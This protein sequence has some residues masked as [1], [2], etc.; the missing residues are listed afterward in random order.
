MSRCSEEHGKEPLWVSDT[1][2]SAASVSHLCCVFW[3]TLVLSLLMS[4]FK[5]AQSHCWK[6]ICDFLTMPHCCEELKNKVI[7]LAMENCIWIWF[8]IDNKNVI[9]LKLNFTIVWYLLDNNILQ[10]MWCFYLLSLWPYFLSPKHTLWIKLSFSSSCF[11]RKYAQCACLFHLSVRTSMC[12]TELPYDLH[13][14]C[15]RFTF[16]IHILSAG[17]QLSVSMSLISHVYRI[18]AANGSNYYYYINIVFP[19]WFFRACM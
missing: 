13:T 19:T 3:F 14:S 7:V 16:Y 12:Q 9:V 2:H 17:R 4:T 15:S 10:E 1:F 6:K 11:T 5:K 8:E 18:P